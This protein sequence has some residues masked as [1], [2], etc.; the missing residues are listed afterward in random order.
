MQ[1]VPQRRGH[2][3][4][5]RRHN[6]A[7][8]DVRTVVVGRA[9]KKMSASSPAAHSP[10]YTSPSSSPNMCGRALSSIIY[11]IVVVP[12]PSNHPLHRHRN[13][14]HIGITGRSVAIAQGLPQRRVIRSSLL[15]PCVST[16]RE[17]EVTATAGTTGPLPTIVGAT[18]AGHSEKE[19]MLK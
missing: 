13:N 8:H 17:G 18:T 9:D 2:A 16:A 11:G 1:K 12:S 10:P 3:C 14:C 4:T 6:V 7:Q 15:C 5:C 19:A